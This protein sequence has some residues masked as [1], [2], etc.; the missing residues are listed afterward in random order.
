MTRSKK[1][2]SPLNGVTQLNA[3]RWF[4]P[5]AL[6]R[7]EFYLLTFFLHQP[8]VWLRRADLAH[9]I[10]KS[11]LTPHDIQCLHRL[12]RYGCLMAD[13][14]R[15][16]RTVVDHFWAYALDSWAYLPPEFGRPSVMIK[17][18]ALDDFGA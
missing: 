18:W 12:V 3:R 8:G 5:L 14:F 7:H 9:Q 10:G 17:K 13:R 1:R 16:E 4:A 2:P 6:S 11:R 15:S